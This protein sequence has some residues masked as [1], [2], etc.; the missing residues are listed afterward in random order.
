V[1]L[2]RP[3]RGSVSRPRFLRRRA[4]TEGLAALHAELTRIDPAAA[5]RIHVNDIRRIERALEVFHLTGQ[6][7]SAL[8]KQWDRIAP[9]RSD[10]SWTLIGLRRP[11][12]ITNRRINDRV[13]RMI[14]T[15]LIEEARTIWTDPRGL[16]TQARQAVGYAELFDHFT[17]GRTQEEA[18]EKIKIN[19]RRLAKHQRTWLKRLP[20]V[21]WL[22]TSEDESFADSLS[23]ALQLV[24]HSP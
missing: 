11:K 14:E 12:E 20:E 24:P 6:P 22:D 15:G 17:G 1:L 23:Q 21:H 7:I 8:Q 18:I 9:R 3:V 4:E 2:P 19:S 5:D 16:G 13:R 10:W